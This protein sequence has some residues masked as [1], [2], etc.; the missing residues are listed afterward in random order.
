[1][2]DVY[3]SIVPLA[4]GVEVKEGGGNYNE[5]IIQFG[6]WSTAGLRKIASLGQIEENEGLLPFVR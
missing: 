3:T 6:V 1:M 2:T 4:C 5:A